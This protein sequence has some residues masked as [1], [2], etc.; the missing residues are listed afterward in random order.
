LIHG[1]EDSPWDRQHVQARRRP[2]LA[3]DDALTRVVLVVNEMRGPW[4]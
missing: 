1:W 2:N 4:P 3:R